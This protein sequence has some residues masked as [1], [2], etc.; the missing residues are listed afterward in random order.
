MMRIFTSS[1]LA[2]NDGKG[3]SPRR[4]MTNKPAITPEEIRPKGVFFVSAES[5]EM[6]ASQN[7]PALANIC[8]SRNPPTMRRTEDSGIP[9]NR[10]TVQANSA[11][12]TWPV[13]E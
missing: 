4:A 11:S 8:V 12:P 7:K 9:A 5:P 2:K 10:D 6:P 13:D 1:H 3:G